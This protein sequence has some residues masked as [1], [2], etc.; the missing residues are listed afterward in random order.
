MKLIEGVPYFRYR[1]QFKLA[2]GRRRS[3]VRWSPGPPWVYEEVGRELSSRFGHEGVL[4]QS[5]TVREA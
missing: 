4:F 1:I 2:D 3:W 5:C